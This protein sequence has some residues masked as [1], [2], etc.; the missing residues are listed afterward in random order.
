MTFV[1]RPQEQ[2]SERRPMSTLSVHILQGCIPETEQK[3]HAEMW[4]DRGSS[5]ASKS[6][7]EEG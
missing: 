7:Q 1:Q 6:G 3:L 4:A 5:L 2:P